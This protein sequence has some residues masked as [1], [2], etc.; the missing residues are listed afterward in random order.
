MQTAFVRLKQDL[1]SAP[2]LKVPNPHGNF[3]VNTDASED[4][5]AVGAV[6]T[7]DGHPCAF[8]SAKLNVHEL[9]YPV[10]DK[11]LLAIIHALRKWR[12]FLLGKKF[13][14]YTDHR[15]L[16]HLHTQKNLNNRQRRW[17]DFLADFDMEIVYKEGKKNVV[18]DA[19]SRVQ[20]NAISP[21]QDEEDLDNIRGAYDA[22]DTKD[23]KDI[24]DNLRAGNEDPHNSPIVKYK[25]ENRLLFFRNNSES[26]WKLCVAGR[27]NKDKL[28][29]DHHD[30]P[31]AGHS[32][33]NRTYAKLARSFY[34]PRMTKD[35]EDW[36][37]KCPTC[38]VSKSSS[39]RPPQGLLQPM[40]IPLLPWQSIAMDFTGPL[41]TSSK[42]GNDFLLVITD[43]LTKMVHPIPCKET[44][45]AQQVAD[46]LFENIFRLHGRPQSILSDRDPR[47]CSRFWQALQRPLGT[48][49]LMSTTNH[50]QTDGQSERAIRTI[51]TMLRNCT[52]DHAEQW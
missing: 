19:L 23:L 14:V 18:A 44:V 42:N 28:L 39:Q 26:D 21:I 34:R 29:H 35:V 38:Q 10:H 46:L 15:S 17:I 5:K 43:R 45:T 6:L 48:K 37:K 16:Q 7:Q 25:W 20:L 31:I 9:N 51:E 24:I 13:T 1:C 47:C 50:P 49:L 12:P 30:S 2:C 22:E 8:E 27:R 32:G 33:A 36:T 11:E 4:A 52:L 40:E 3:E 41:S